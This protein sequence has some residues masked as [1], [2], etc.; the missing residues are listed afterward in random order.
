MNSKIWCKMIQPIVKLLPHSPTESQ[1]IDSAWVAARGCYS[2]KSAWE[3]SQQS[4]TF[5][6]KF[7]LLQR[8]LKDK[9]RTTLTHIN[10][11]FSFDKVPIKIATQ[12]TRS[13]VGTCF[14]QRSTRYLPQWTK[15]K[16]AFDYGVQP[17][18]LRT[19][20]TVKY[21]DGHY[22]AIVK[23]FEDCYNK[24]AAAYENLRALGVPAEDASYILNLGTFTG[25]TAT[26]NLVSFR[27]WINTRYNHSTGKAQGEHEELARVALDEFKVH[28][29]NIAKEIFSGD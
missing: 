22:L 4:D 19:H 18:R 11:S 8:L 3:I 16:R 26:F 17:I 25:L 29:P 14:D 5:E 2:D 20:D 24:C 10:F 1:I 12:L 27:H 15:G 7:K 13:Q 21:S 6:N 9:H 28:Y 23:Q